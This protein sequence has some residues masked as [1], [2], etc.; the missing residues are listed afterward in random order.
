[1]VLVCIIGLSI[2]T[3]IDYKIAKTFLYPP[4]IF[5][6]LWAILLVALVL[7]GETFYPVT[8]KTLG[9]YFVG[10]FSFSLGGILALITHKNNKSRIECINELK[11]SNQRSLFIHKCLKIMLAFLILLFPYYVYRMLSFGQTSG[12]PNIWIGIRY[13]TSILM[14]G[15]LG[16]FS[17][18]IAL[19]QFTAFISFYETRRHNDKSYISYLSIIVAL[20]Y[21]FFTVS[22]LGIINL[23]VGL[24]GID[25]VSS[26]RFKLKPILI[27]SFALLIS[28][29][30]PA[31]LLNKGGSLDAGIRENLAGVLK[32]FQVYSLGGLVAFDSVVNSP[33]IFIN[34]YIPTLRFFYSVANMFGANVYFPAV[35]TQVVFTPQP[36]N[37]YTIYSSYFLD[38]GLGGI[39]IILII[40]GFL[41]VLIYKQA[42]KHRPEGTILYGIMLG[43]LVVSCANEA[44]WTTLSSW[45]QA[46][47]LI[48]ILYRFPLKRINSAG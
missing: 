39:I 11:C 29:A 26:G 43:S 22:R 42:L 7:S 23:I 33:Y 25:F 13:Q 27:G 9:I 15:K 24:I 3:L 18:I 34:A 47:V 20:L 19:S 37:V 44:F 46:T 14:E 30:I 45:I 21:Q 28:F 4:A 1:M 2:L 31:I 12:M 32:S 40:I 48:I 5:S 10:A 8:S 6:A 17:Y 36:T 16:I 41:S 38:F 35:N